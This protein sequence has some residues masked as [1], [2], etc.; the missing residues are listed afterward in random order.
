M[1]Y[2]RLLNILPCAVYSSISL[3]LH[4]VHT[5]LNLLT[6]NFYSTC[7]PIPLPLGNHK[8]VLYACESL[9]IET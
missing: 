1:I 2:H 6:P 5:S 9:S 4:S 7:L 8:S 3:F